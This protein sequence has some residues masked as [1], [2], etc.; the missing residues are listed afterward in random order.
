METLPPAPGHRPEPVAGRR[1]RRFLVG[2][3]TGFA[4][5]VVALA[6]AEGSEF[7]AAL[8]EFPAWAV[9]VSIG[10]QLAWLG[11][12]GEA[13]RLALNAVGPREV[14]RRGA[15]LANA[16]AFGVGAVQSLATVPARA[17]ALR[18]LAPERSPTLE[19]TLVADA[20]VLALEGTLMGL[21]LVVAVLT[22]PGLPAW[23]ALAVL[24][25]G[26]LGLVALA[27][28]REKLEGRGLAAGLRVLADRRRRVK[29]AGLAVVMSA[30][31]M[32]RSW[33]VLAGF[34]LPHGFASVA[35]FLAALGFAASLPIGLASTPT[36]ALALF[37][38][39]DPALAAAAGIGM[40][41]TSLIAV[42]LYGALSSGSL[43]L[44]SRR[45]LRA[46]GAA[47]RAAVAE[48]HAGKAA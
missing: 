35:A 20:P 43:M 28:L 9:L 10:T 13:W 29:L 42:A 12:R 4:V 41:A 31:A 6:I 37:G 17:L 46:A 48:R 36:A 23:G 15:H 34:G 7:G 44:A 38:S 30:L 27:L 39:R 21:L 32:A 19:Q 16:L 22:A 40:A 11:C 1:R 33:T 8:G 2:A 18:R 47:T 26:A 3:T 25:A 45:E 24:T 5:L 14:S